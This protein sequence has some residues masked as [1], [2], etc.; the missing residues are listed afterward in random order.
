MRRWTWALVAEFAV[1][2][3]RVWKVMAWSVLIVWAATTSI[4]WPVLRWMME[5]W[6]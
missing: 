2:V 3:R 6:R 1:K 4:A 5:G